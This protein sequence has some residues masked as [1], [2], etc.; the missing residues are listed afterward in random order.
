MEGSNR[1]LLRERLGASAPR[2]YLPS[3]HLLCPSALGFL[4]ILAA[5]AQIRALRPV[6]LLGIP[7][8]YAFANAVEWWAHK[9]MLHHRRWFAPVLYDQHTPHHH[10]LFVTEDMAIRSRWECRLVLIPAF[11]LMLIFLATLPVGILLDRGGFHNLACLYIA[12][13][14]AYAISYE[15]LHLSYHLPADHPVRRLALI[16]ALARHHEIHHD[17]Q[18][19]SAWN[20][21]VTI[22]LWDWVM[23]TVA[24]TSDR[25]L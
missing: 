1:Q 17:P 24:A 9:Y 16:R 6:E 23:G 2:W 22:P 21:N 3:V 12:V 11:G 20:F 5:L 15:W 8:F 4:L 14:V 18:L 19:M 10:M 7:F 13:G 25:K